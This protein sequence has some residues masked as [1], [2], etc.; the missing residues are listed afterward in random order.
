MNPV[1]E[2][3]TGHGEYEPSG[4]SG[5]HGKSLW[6]LALVSLGIFLALGF[7]DAFQVYTYR[8]GSGVPVPWD[9]AIRRSLPFWALWWPLLPLVLWVS[10]L[11]KFSKEEWVRS[12]VMHLLLAA[13]FSLGHLFVYAIL[14]DI[15]VYGNGL[16]E[17]IQ[18]LWWKHVSERFALDLVTYCAIVSGH[19]ATQYYQ[20]FIERE[21][22]ARRLEVE[23]ARLESHLARAELNALKMQLHPHFLFNTLH[24]ISTMVLKG[25]TKAANQMI[26]RL[27]DFLRLTLENTGRVEVP[28]EVEFEFLESYLHI[29]QARYPDCMSVSIQIE[30]EAR[31]AMVPN[32]ILQPLVE[33]AINHGISRNPETGRIEVEA[34]KEGNDLV[35]EIR[36][37][38]P[39]L[40]DGLEEGVGISNTRARLA[41]L[42]SGD[43]ELDLRSQNGERTVATVRIPFRRMSEEEESG[44]GEIPS[45]S[46]D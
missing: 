43:A 17:N 23:K 8:A 31:E 2:S 35:F 44:L 19:S 30:P 20:R 46:A 41:Q 15:W 13:L 40:K 32:L 14:R 18:F 26:S 1:R 36:D 10:S 33:N 42:Y 4:T 25:D 21:S 37:D 6:T 11:Y 45:G 12:G 29:Q 7:L 34:R 38:G 9:G 5:P 22:A 28:L 3:N 27:S 24:A 16:P 39:G